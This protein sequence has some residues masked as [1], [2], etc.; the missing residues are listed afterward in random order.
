[1]HLRKSTVDSLCLHT[2]V[3]KKTTTLIKESWKEQNL[4]SG[5]VGTAV[6]QQNKALP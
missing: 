4:F 2:C 1:M 3:F 5:F 6:I